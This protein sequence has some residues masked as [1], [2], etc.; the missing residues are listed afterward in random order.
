LNCL[1]RPLK[2]SRQ[3]H[4]PGACPCAG[5][6]RQP[7]NVPQ[8]LA[9]SLRITHGDLTVSGGDYFGWTVMAIGTVAGIA[10]LDFI[11]RNLPDTLDQD[12]RDIADGDWPHVP[13]GLRGVKAG[14]NKGGR[15][16][17]TMGADLLN[18]EQSH[19]RF[20]DIARPE[21]PL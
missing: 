1:R 18:T 14:A 11:Q 8:G 9:T 16:S 2:K 4:D 5:Q 6:G 21:R 12:G 15:G 19:N 3:Q 10:F 20:P 17:G 7:N 13:A